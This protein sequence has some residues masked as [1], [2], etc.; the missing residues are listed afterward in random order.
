MRNDRHQRG[1]AMRII[2]TGGGTGGHV[3]PALSIADELKRR[4]PQAEILFVGTRKGLESTAVPRAGYPIEYIEAAG[5]SRRRMLENLKVPLVLWRGAASC[6]RILKEFKPDLVV[7]TGGYVSG[8]MVLTAAMKGVRTCIHEQNAYPGLTNRM[9][10]LVVSDIFTGFEP[11][12]AYFMRKSR[13]VHTGN[14]VRRVFYGVT[15]AV[16]RERLSIPS[17]QF[18]VLSFGGSG[19]ADFMNRTM[20]ACAG[21]LRDMPVWITHVT[22][23]RY[24]ERFREAFKENERLEVHAYIEEMADHMAASDLVVARAGAI[25]VAEILQLGKPALLVPSPN[26]T[27]NH[28][29]HNAKALEEAGCARLLEEAALSGERLADEILRLKARPD[30][31]DGMR[32]AAAAY[33]E[34]DAAGTIASRILRGETP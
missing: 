18:R 10:G 9:L 31:L 15:R 5:L 4:D 32:R 33:M 25:T 17:G 7:G 27:G 23:R 11:A 24:F 14:P 3:Y 6:R 34:M 20:E 30:L 12:R 2:M 8:P 29:Y 28:Q 1:K 22:G 13:V 26:V 19:G 16:A 21:K